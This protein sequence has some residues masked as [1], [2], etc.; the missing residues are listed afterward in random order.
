[1]LYKDII[2]SRS[3][4]FDKACAECWAKPDQPATIEL[5]EDDVNVF[6]VYMNIL[7]RN[8]P[9]TGALQYSLNQA[10][11][12]DPAETP[13]SLLVKTYLLADKLRDCSSANVISDALLMYWFRGKLAYMGTQ[14]ASIVSLRTLAGSPLRKLFLDFYADRTSAKAL[15]DLAADARVTRDFLSEI[16][17][18]VASACLEQQ[19]G[20]DYEST[21]D[22]GYVLK[23][24][25]RYHQHDDQDGDC[26][27]QRTDAIALAYALHGERYDP[28]KEAALV[29]N[30]ED[31]DSS[32]EG[33]E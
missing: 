2:C 27:Q 26:Q 8:L 17:T 31:E 11:K 5:P 15:L 7:Y 28:E 12:S 21:G 10:Q 33:S 20:D 6:N 22:G 13:Q 19:M 16:L 1:M 3:A 29:K 23:N 32:S 25:C 24:G 9:E 18:R 30:N 14:A 4:F